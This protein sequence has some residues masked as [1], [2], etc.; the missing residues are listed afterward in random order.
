MIKKNDQTAQIRPCELFPLN[1][2]AMAQG[3]VGG[4]GVFALHPFAQL[5]GVGHLLS[6]TQWH[7]SGINLGPWACHALGGHHCQQPRNT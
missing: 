5:H 2:F 6:G 1:V 4:Q 7:P 3:L